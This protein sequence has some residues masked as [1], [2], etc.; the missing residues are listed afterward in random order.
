[1]IDASEHY[2]TTMPQK[3]VHGSGNLPPNQHFAEITIPNGTTYEMVEPTRLPGWD[4]PSCAVA[5]AF[6]ERWQ[7]ERRSALLIVPNVVAR[8]EHN[9]LINPGHAEARQSRDPV[10]ASAS[11]RACTAP[12]KPAPTT[13]TGRIGGCSPFLACRRPGNGC[14]F[15]ASVNRTPGQAKMRLR[16]CR[17][18][19]ARMLPASP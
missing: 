12:A 5:E 10:P 8:M 11:P 1:M 2:S 3:L 18:D 13:R 4:D 15:F 16:C 6:G 19:A 14:G 17:P 9:I 7:Q